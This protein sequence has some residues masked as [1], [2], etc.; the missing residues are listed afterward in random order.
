VGV[1]LALPEMWDGALFGSGAALVGHS[2]KWSARDK[3][4]VAM[5]VASLAVLAVCVRVCIAWVRV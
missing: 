3:A 2:Q 1:E 5:V 4:H